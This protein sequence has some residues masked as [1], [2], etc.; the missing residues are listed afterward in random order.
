MLHYVANFPVSYQGVTKYLG[1]SWR[2]GGNM[3]KINEVKPAGHEVRARR[4]SGDQ[5]LGPQCVED[6]DTV[7]LPNDVVSVATLAPPAVD[8]VDELKYVAREKLGRGRIDPA[9]RGKLCEELGAELELLWREK[10][11]KMA[12]THKPRQHEGVKLVNQLLKSRNQ[13][14]PVKV[15][16]RDIAAV[17]Q[18]RL[19]QER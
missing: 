15:V 14:L 2:Q 7:Y 5:V 11:G 3:A 6:P 16:E 10:L 4:P 8:D 9:A 13:T 1:V 19:L 12:K 18:R 17:V